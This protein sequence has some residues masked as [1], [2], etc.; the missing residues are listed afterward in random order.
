MPYTRLIAAF[1]FV[2]MVFLLLCL[3]ANHPYFTVESM[4]LAAIFAGILWLMALD[5]NFI[6]D[7][8]V[9]LFTA[10]FTQRIVIVYFFPESLDH[11]DYL[12]FTHHDF[13]QAMYFLALSTFAALSAYVCSL[14]VGRRLPKSC[15]QLSSVI[16]PIHIFGQKF[17]FNN[18]F[19]IYAI[20]AALL[21]IIQLYLITF[22]AVGVTGVPFERQY[23]VIF[24][25][26]NFLN[27]LTFLPF[28]VILSNEKGKNKKLAIVLI[29]LMIL[30]ALFRVS[31]GVILSFAL[32]YLICYYLVKGPIPKKYFKYA[33]VG[34][35]IT[36]FLYAPVIMYLRSLAIQYSL[37]GNL[38][39][40]L[41]NVSYTDFFMFSDKSFGFLQRLGGLDWLLGC[42]NVGRDSFPWWA[43]FTG[44]LLMVVK[45]FVPGDTLM[46]IEGYVPVSI[47]IPELMRGWNM[48]FHPGHGE[49]LGGAGMAYVYWGLVGGV[50]FFYVWVFL[51]LLM[52]NSK[53][54]VI[55][56]NLFVLWL[57]VDVFIGGG[58]ITPLCRIYEAFISIVIFFVVYCVVK[59]KFNNR[60]VVKLY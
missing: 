21:T 46:F 41:A 35:L 13:T 37:V 38:D 59:V 47:I 15:A 9:Y 3:P 6:M 25:F 34:L 5:G 22:M 42:I 60:C 29:A 49:L 28:I 39:G 52:F 48:A 56:K 24:R 8:L 32:Q 30:N 2:L 33:F 45:T 57:L 58:F 4:L 16:A 10:Y 20:T 54:H 17:S 51:L 18:L 53:I 7:L 27:S 43:S 11:Q 14:Y 44:D 23:A 12:I 31:K 26:S 19:K 36:I 50:L 55:Y 1:F 40:A